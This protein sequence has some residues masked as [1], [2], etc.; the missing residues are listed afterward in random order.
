MSTRP[1][2]DRTVLIGAAGTGTSFAI[3]TRLR[4]T[5]GGEV[6]LVGMDT[7]PPELVT[8]SLLCDGF[9]TVPRA[10]DAAF[11]I[12]LEGI[13]EAEA[14]T[15]YIPIL[16]DEIAL[17]SSLLPLESGIDIVA[18]AADMAELSRDK[19]QLADRLGEW[20][21]AAAKTCLPEDR[22]GKGPW[23]MKPRNGFG[24][25]SAHV[26]DAGFLKGAAPDDLGGM[27]L[28]EVCSPPE[29]T[30]DSFFD[31]ATGKGRALCRERL[32]TKAGVC[33]KAR[34]FED[35]RLSDMAARIGDA[36][37]QRGTICFQ[38]MDAGD[39]WTVTDLNLRPGAGTAMTCAAGFDVLSAF[40]ACRWGL[41]TDCYF[42]RPSLD[43]DVIVTR[44]YAEFVTR[45]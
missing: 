4:A 2:H 25:R 9:H 1:N 20:G 7:N 3:A 27:I 26:V 43:R 31:A 16:N 42:S 40:L 14:P 28:Q 23:F 44:Q 19:L 5:W 41:P 29:V 30:V 39:G 24:S 11:A 10:D 45:A 15:T 8:T 18:P 12:A 6:R 32:E 13:F 17:A 21:V 37:G 38:V 22:A 35:R 33:T 36:L 34:V